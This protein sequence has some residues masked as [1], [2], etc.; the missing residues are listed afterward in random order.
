[1]R[2]KEITGQ[3]RRRRRLG[4]MGE[5]ILIVDDEENSRIGLSKILTKSGYEVLTAENGRQA[6]DTI[7]QEGCYLVI[8]DMKM[9]EMDGIQLLR[10]I[11]QYDPDIGVIIVTAY[12]E[13]DSYL[14]SMNLG[15]FEYL[16]KPI[17]VDELKKVIS[18]VLEKK[19]EGDV[20]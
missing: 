18:K 15:A 13:V 16:N 2:H 9:P 8:T 6:L 20:V 12:G 14:E 17:K 1:L 5:K 7:K 11:K 4:I 19:E 10:E 3:T